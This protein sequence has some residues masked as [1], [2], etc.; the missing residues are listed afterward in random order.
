MNSTRAY[1]EPWFPTVGL[2]VQIALFVVSKG[3]ALGISEN[4]RRLKS[5]IGDMASQTLLSDVRLLEPTSPSFQLRFSP[6]LVPGWNAL[7][8]FPNQLGSLRKH[9]TLSL[10]VKALE[11]AVAFFHGLLTVDDVGGASVEE[12]ILLQYKR[13][14][15]K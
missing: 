10:M 13:P 3:T 11:M 8:S 5:F 2:K 9:V 14:D 6:T 4:A 12:C 1:L 7:F 15:A